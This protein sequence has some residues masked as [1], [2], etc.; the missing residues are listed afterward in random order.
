MDDETKAFLL[1][2]EGRLLARIN[3]G[4]EK[5]LL[6]LRDTQ[7]EVR[8]VKAEQAATRTF[9]DARASQTEVLINRLFDQLNKRLDQTERSVEERLRRLEDRE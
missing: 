5:L 7:T 8:S 3:D 2:I 9:I 6:D 4:Y 1:A